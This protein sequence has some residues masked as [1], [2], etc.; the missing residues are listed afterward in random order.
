MEI[1]V[2]GKVPGKGSAVL[3]SIWKKGINGECI[4]IDIEGVPCHMW[5]VE[6]KST[7]IE[8]SWMPHQGD[9]SEHVARVESG[10]AKIEIVMQGGPE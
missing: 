10:P 3:K 1:T 5:A 9:G 2:K 7:L 6:V 8:K 4:E